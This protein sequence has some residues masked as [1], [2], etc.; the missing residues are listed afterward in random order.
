[1]LLY[2][3]RGVAAPDL[4]HCSLLRLRRELSPFSSGA[5]IQL[6][7]LLGQHD[8]DA[9]ADRVGELGGARDQLLSLRVVFKRALGQGADQNLEQLGV[10]AAGGAFG[11]RHWW[12]GSSAG[13]RSAAGA[14]AARQAAGW[15]RDDGS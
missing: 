15:C 7:G 14:W 1:H 6:A 10:D 4:Q 13:A 9:V 5:S 12:L 3:D 2:I 8:R 11:G